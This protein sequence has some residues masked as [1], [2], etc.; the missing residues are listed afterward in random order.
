MNLWQKIT[1]KLA[2]TADKIG[3]Q[4]RSIFSDGKIDLQSLQQLEDT[5]IMA[6]VGP[7]TTQKI[8]QTLK[9]NADMLA[10]QDDPAESI[11]QYLSTLLKQRFD[12]CQRCFSLDHQ[13]TL[14]V[15]LFVGVNGSGKTT[16]IAKLATFIKQQNK[17]T[18]I[19]AG[20]T[21]RAAGASQMRLWGKRINVDVIEGNQG[22]DA[23]ALAYKA[24][25]KAKDEHYDYL[26]IDTAGRLHTKKDLMA[27]LGKIN[28]VI[29]K[30]IDNAS[31]EVV[32]VLDG[33]TGQNALIQVEEF[34]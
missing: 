7:A 12:D 1:D 14:K 29:S 4:I 19:A 30:Q 22:S 10:R 6:D 3:G 5:L 23:A 17:K 11:R 24:C 32:M 13:D 20:D 26:L 8:I 15:I 18:L 25:A 31:Y 34:S 28:R 16:S 21:F 9:E 33:P 2:K 27:E